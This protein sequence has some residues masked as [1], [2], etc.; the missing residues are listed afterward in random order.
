MGLS[1]LGAAAAAV[2]GREFSSFIDRERPRPHWFGDIVVGQA[3]YWTIILSPDRLL[4]MMGAAVVGLL[5]LHLFTFQSI[6]RAGVGLMGSCASILYTVCLL[7]F[8]PLIRGLPHGLSWIYFIMLITWAGDTGAYV[9]G[10]TFGR[11]RL[12][13]QV[14][15]GK[16]VEG[17]VG[18]VVFAIGAAFGAKLTFFPSLTVAECLILAPLLDVAGVAGDLAES[19]MKRAAGVKDS[20]GLFPGH[21]GI[22]DRIDSLLFSSPLLYAYLDLVK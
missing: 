17:A 2:A 3:L 11:H 4:P 5:V 7:S 9:A 18:G 20:G 15:P 8:I 13:P 19:L 12:Y 1:L 14:S 21:G 10:R 6:E 22:L 16:T